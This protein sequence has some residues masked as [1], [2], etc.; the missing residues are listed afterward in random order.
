MTDKHKNLYS[1]LAAAQAEMGPALKDAVNP[2]FKQGGKEAKYADLAAVLAAVMPPLNKH[3]IAMI[4]PT[5][6]DETGRYVK[7]ILIFGETGETMEW[8]VPLIIV[9]NDMQGYGGAVTYARRYGAMC[10]GIAPEDDDGNTA[11]KATPK[12]IS[13]AEMN[14]QLELLDH[15]LADCYTEISLQNLWGQWKKKMDKDGWPMSADP[16]DETYHR[17]VAINKFGDRKKEII[18]A[19]EN[20]EVKDLREYAE[21]E[22]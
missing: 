18:K 11:A 16:E 5:F 12:K 21:A 20:S 4:Q 14:R 13:H 19:I 15:D 10:V 17:Q 22:Q 2:A 3:G 8:R 9:K 1:A 7:T 6:D